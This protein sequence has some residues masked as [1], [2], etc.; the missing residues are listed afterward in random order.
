MQERDAVIGMGGKKSRQ[1]LLEPSLM[2]SDIARHL[3]QGAAA[4]EFALLLEGAGPRLGQSLETVEAVEAPHAVARDVTQAR[5]IGDA[6]FMAAMERNSD[7]IVMQCYAPLLVN[8]NTGAWQWRPN[9]IGFDAL[10]SYGAPSY[11]AFTM[12]SQNVGDQILK[13]SMDGTPVQ[14]SATRDSKSGEI[15]LKLVNPQGTEELVN[16]ELKG[17][18]SV[19]SPATAITIAAS[20]EETN[21]LEEPVKVVPK[22]SNVEGIKPSFSYKVPANGIVVLKLKA[23]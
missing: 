21:S 13:L 17:V 5:A 12:F 19:A 23:G 14:A 9:L 11:Y 4:A 18:A 7:I 6:A 2:Q 1:R 8:T 20:P 3:R 15:F 16:I 22:Q 10:H